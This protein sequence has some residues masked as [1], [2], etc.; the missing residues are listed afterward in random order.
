MVTLHDGVPVV[1]VI[2][3][4]VAKA[5]VQQLTERTLFTGL[6]PNDRHAGVHEPRASGDERA[7]HR[8]AQRHLFA[9]ACC[10]TSC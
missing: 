10:S 2:D 7:G 9:R 8:H 5:T 6:R 1:K 3:F 4:G